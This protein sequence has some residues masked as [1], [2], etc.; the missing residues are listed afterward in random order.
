[1]ALLSGSKLRK[2]SGKAVKGRGTKCKN[3]TAGYETW[4]PEF[5]QD[6]GNLLKFECHN[7]EK[8]RAKLLKFKCHNC[9]KLR[10][11]LLKFECHNCEKSF[12]KEIKIQGTDLSI[13]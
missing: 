5:W 6:K 2:F 1:M 8:L 10:V 3:P 11:K 12:G 9:E 13:A 4:V 7:C